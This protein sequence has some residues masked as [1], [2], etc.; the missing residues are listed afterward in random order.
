MAGSDRMTAGP[1]LVP[2][3]N[4]ALRRVPTWTLYVVGAAWAAWLFWLGLTGGLGAEPINELERR[5][6]ELAIN[7]IV[8]GLAVTPL[9]RH[10]GLNFMPFR[11]AIGVLSFF[12]VI[13][14]LLVWAV[15]DVQTLARVW[16]DLLE[17]PY[18]TIGMAGFL[19]LLP[20]GLTSNDWSVRRLGGAAWRRLHRLVYPAAVLGALHYVWLA[21]GFQIEPLLYMAAILG[22]LA[23]RFRP[24]TR[25]G[26]A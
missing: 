4:G 8:A 1:G 13:A 24:A 20:L 9:R 18:I 19:L 2:A 3:V 25:G 11:R 6:G 14:H 15:L 23:L 12:F 16:A 22:L 5:Y 17:R 7:L 26:R 21:K 10:V